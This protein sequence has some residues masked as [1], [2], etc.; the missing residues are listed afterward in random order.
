M[1]NEMKVYILSEMTKDEREK[2]I[3]LFGSQEIEEH[4]KTH[5]QEGFYDRCCKTDHCK[6]FNEQKDELRNKQEEKIKQ[7]EDIVTKQNELLKQIIERLK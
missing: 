1:E 2:L 7:L 4:C 6:I 3:K 5:D